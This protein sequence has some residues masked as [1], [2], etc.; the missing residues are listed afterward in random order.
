[1]TAKALKRVVEGGSS[2]SSSSGQITNFVLDKVRILRCFGE[3]TS[4]RLSFWAENRNELR[5]LNG[6]SECLATVDI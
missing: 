3:V 1:M 5:F 4:V 6:E 2:L